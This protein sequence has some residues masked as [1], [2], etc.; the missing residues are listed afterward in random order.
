[1]KMFDVKK[2]REEAEKELREEAEE[3]AKKKLI[4]KLKELD[5]ARK[6]VRNLERELEEIE[7]DIGE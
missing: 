7:L 6:V 1:M 5:R 3:A 4:S 2:V